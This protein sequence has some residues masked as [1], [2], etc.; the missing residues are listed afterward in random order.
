MEL[1]IEK[2]KADIV[3]T[4]DG[5]AKLLEEGVVQDKVKGG[6]GGVQ[7]FKIEGFPER[8]YKKR[9]NLLM[10]KKTRLI[11]KENELLELIDGIE[12]YIDTIPISRDRL[13]FKGIYL[14][15]KTQQEIAS[16]LFIDRSLVSKILSKYE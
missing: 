12:E 7:G 14:E 11:A 5:I 6:F 3:K 10:K 4:E 1:E 8:E 15:K 9:R 13:I 16:E 2:I